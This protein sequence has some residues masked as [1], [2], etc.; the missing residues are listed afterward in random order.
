MPVVAMPYFVLKIIEQL[1]LMILHMVRILISMTELPGIQ[2][3]GD[4]GPASRPGGQKSRQPDSG[5]DTGIGMEFE[6]Q[7]SSSSGGPANMPLLPISPESSE[8]DSDADTVPFCIH[9][10]WSSLGSNQY[11][12]KARCRLCGE[13]WEGGPNTF[14]P[15][16]L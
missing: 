6:S 14:P 2:Y 3:G 1:L 12:S 15:W 13:R 4:G 11:R 9:W 5:T 10:T 8:I 7:S 16:P